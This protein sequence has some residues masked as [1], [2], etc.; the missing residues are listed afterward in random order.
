MPGDASYT[1]SGDSTL[2]GEIFYTLTEVQVLIERWRQ[3]YNGLRLHSSLGLPATS[4]E[5]DL[6]EPDCA[7]LRWLQ[8]VLVS[9]ELLR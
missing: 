1:T 9:I 4:T 6:V 5:S 7:P 8:P 3:Q 2:N